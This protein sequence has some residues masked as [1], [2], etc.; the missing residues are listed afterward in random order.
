MEVKENIIKLIENL[1]LDII[2]DGQDYTSEELS[3]LLK[4]LKKQI[5]D[6]SG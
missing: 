5:G 3:D 6:F 4:E 2:S 1:R